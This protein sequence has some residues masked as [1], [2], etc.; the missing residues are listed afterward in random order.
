MLASCLAL[1]LNCA[2]QEYPARPVRMVVPFPAGAGTDILARAIG[3]KL[4]EAWGQSVVVENRPGAGGTIGSELVAKAPRDGYTL[5]MGNVSTLAMGPAIY[6][7]V[8]YDSLKDF[9]PVSLVSSS[10]NVVVVHPSLP[11]ASVRELI[12]L[13]RAKPGQLLYS[14]AG[15]G[16]TTHLAGELFKLMAKVDIVHVPYKGTPQAM[17]DLVAGQVQM[18]FTSL[19]S[20]VPLI[21][22]GRLRALATTG[23]KRNP[24]LAGL[25]TVDESGLKGFEVNAWQGI[26]AP[27][28]TP[29]PVIAK[30]NEGIVRTLEMSDVKERLGSIGLVAAGS[31]PERFAEYLRSESVKW[32]GVVKAAGVRAD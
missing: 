31:T 2:A 14:S 4:T 15:S 17:V 22:S 28:G 23:L 13:A 9:A 5:L 10:E 20:G 21:K 18:S 32:A 8:G 12:A 7:N 11:V 29:A 16:T 6:R 3:Q 1:S 25:P 30:L 19:A 27:A 26:L 24:L